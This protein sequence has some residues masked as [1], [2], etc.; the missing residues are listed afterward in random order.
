MT[1][2]NWV[3]VGVGVIAGVILDQ[4]YIW[5]SGASPAA[6]LMGDGLHWTDNFFE[7]HDKPIVALSTVAIALFTISLARATRGLQVFAAKQA[8]DMDVALSAATEQASA[9]T[10]MVSTMRR[11]A[12]TELRAYVFVQSSRI[13][14]IKPGVQPEARVYIHN[15]G[16][17]TRLQPDTPQRRNRVA[18]SFDKLPPPVDA[19]GVESGQNPI[20]SLG[21][22]ATYEHVVEFPMSVS[23]QQYA[24]IADRRITVFVYGDVNYT[25]AFGKSQFL[26]YRMMTGGPVGLRG[27]QLVSCAEGNEASSD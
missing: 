24:A 23:S 22:G 13:D 8:R 6:A 4:V 7:H 15:F 10:Q 16:K 18:V 9:T 5:L 27:N 20:G 3:R 12:E 14:E 19:E 26:R 1:R 17:S 11:T 25:D 2:A 21:P